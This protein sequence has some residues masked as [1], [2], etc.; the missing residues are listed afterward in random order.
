[1]DPSLRSVLP[2][3]IAA[4]A[5]LSW[6]CLLDAGPVQSDA[7]GPSAGGSNG[8]AGAAGTSNTAGSGNAG[9]G[10]G[11][12]GTAGTAGSGT[13]G[14]GTAGSGTAGSNT[15]TSTPGCQQDVDC[16]DSD[17]DPCLVP[18]CDN[19]M[20]G[21][22]V[23]AGAICNST[24]PV[25]YDEGRCDSSGACV[26]APSPKSDLRDMNPGDCQRPVCDGNGTQTTK[27]DDADKPANEDC[28]DGGCS[29]GVPTH[30]PANEG[31]LCD[32]GLCCNGN[33]CVA[34]VEKCCGKECCVSL[35]TC[36]PD[37]TCKGL[38]SCNP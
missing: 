7:N 14:S 23:D 16:M 8:G 33:C 38:G 3:L 12:N 5:C 28:T 34:V 20:C 9:S 25:C 31:G 22:Q 26:L 35:D 6:G 37:G 10:T 36:C 17:E 1:M 4:A 11:G 29:D 30:T 19:S 24:P 15:T 18:K 32:V 13:A 2:V 21:A 27:P